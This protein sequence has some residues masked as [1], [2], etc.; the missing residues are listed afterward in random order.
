MNGKDFDFNRMF[1]KMLNEQRDEGK[2]FREEKRFFK[3]VYQELD[4]LKTYVKKEAE[5]ADSDSVGQYQE[6]SDAVDRLQ[7][8]M[9]EHLAS[10]K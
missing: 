4:D 7:N 8:M 10:Y 5:Q 6:I 2:H 9:S 3:K 1:D